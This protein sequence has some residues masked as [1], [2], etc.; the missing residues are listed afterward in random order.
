MSL[1]FRAIVGVG[2]RDGQSPE[3]IKLRGSVDQKNKLKEKS[4]LLHVS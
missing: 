3:S 4:T 2:V 1:F